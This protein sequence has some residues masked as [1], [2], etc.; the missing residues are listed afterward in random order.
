MPRNTD[1]STTH[2]VE[3]P[4]NSKGG[5]KKEPLS[6]WVAIEA[7]PGKVYYHNTETGEDSWEKPTDFTAKVAPKPNIIP[8]GDNNDPMKIA[9]MREERRLQCER[10]GVSADALNEH[11]EQTP[12]AAIQ[13]ALSSFKDKDQVEVCDC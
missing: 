5:P 7:R 13:A 8:F 11:E 9:V 12:E 10:L 3:A 6:R 2:E 4:K 1:I